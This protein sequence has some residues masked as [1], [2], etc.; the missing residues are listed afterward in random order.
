MNVNFS[1]KEDSDPIKHE[2]LILHSKCLSMSEKLQAIT[3][4]FA[5]PFKCIVSDW[6]RWVKASLL[7]DCASKKFHAI[8]KKL[9]QSFA[10]Q[11]L[12]NIAA[13]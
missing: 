10:E 4:F 12:I 9:L 6:K 7:M 2:G 1:T 3:F 11:Q 13:N 8:I 5:K